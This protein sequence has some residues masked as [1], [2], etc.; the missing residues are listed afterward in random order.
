MISCG[1]R[2]ALQGDARR[3]A[4]ASCQLPRQIRRG[5]RLHSC[6]VRLRATTSLQLAPDAECYWHR[7]C[8]PADTP[9]IRYRV[10]IADQ[11][12]S[13][14]RS[15]VPASGSA[16]QPQERQRQCARGMCLVQQIARH[17]QA[18]AAIGTTAGAHG[19][20]GKA[21]AAIL[22]RFADLVVGDPITDADV[23]SIGRTLTIRKGPE[24]IAPQT[25]IGVNSIR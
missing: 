18:R 17:L 23:H 1:T 22:G 8:R 5:N 12:S 3:L 21:R 7:R 19:Q 15:R 6:A 25:R 13:G 20:F 9:G 16:S 10:D 11:P 24:L 4:A 14:P 2:R